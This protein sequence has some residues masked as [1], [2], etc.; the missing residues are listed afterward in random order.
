MR[1]F[2]FKLVRK[3]FRPLEP[4]A[5]KWGAKNRVVA[6]LYYAFLNR[7]FSYE[8]QTFLAGRVA[9]DHSLVSEQLRAGVITEDEAENHRLSHII[10]RSVGCQEVEEVDRLWLQLEPGD[11]WLICSDGLHGKVKNKEIFSMV[12]EQRCQAI[13]P[14]I[15]LANERGGEDNISVVILDIQA[16]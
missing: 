11:L 13:D 10:T 14:L 2:L 5:A 6:A 3:I 16:P 4:H 7:S 1:I 8:Q 9:Y 12:S 15:E